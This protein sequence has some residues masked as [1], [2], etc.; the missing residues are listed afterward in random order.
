MKRKRA[1]HKDILRNRMILVSIIFI[2]LILGVVIYNKLTYVDKNNDSNQSSEVKKEDEV[3]KEEVKEDEKEKVKEVVKEEIT[4][5]AAGDCTLGTDTKFSTYGSFQDEVKKSG[6]DYS[7]F[8]KNVAPIFKEDDYTLVNLETTF[9][10]ATVKANKGSGTVYHFKGP[11]EYVNILSSSSIEGVTIDNNHIY[12]YRQQGLDDTINTLKESKIDYCG[13]GNKIIKE[14]KGIKIGI[15]GYS[16]F[17]ISNEM[18]ANIKND[19]ATLKNEGCSLV[20]TYF[21]WGSEL[22]YEPNE[23]Q[24]VMA[25]FAIDNGSDMVLGSHPHVIQTIEKYNGK[26]I[27]Y[28]LGNF[29]FGGNSNPQDYRTFIIQGKIKLEDKVIKG[30]EFKV[31]PTIISSV[32]N[33]ND[34]VPTPATGESASEIINK[35]NELSPTLEGKINLEFFSL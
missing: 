5:S 17:G 25:R 18:Q 14:V 35:L 4:I 13:K 9:T 16:S 6:N 29:S 8:M 28:S 7:H 24:R 31:I 2:L 19:I 10:N 34:Y 20:V 21:H 1:R 12:D 32:D 3:V 33:R 11:K 26:L 30:I 15:L 22:A 27:A 23:A